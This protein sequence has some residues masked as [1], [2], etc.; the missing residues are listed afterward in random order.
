MGDA[1]MRLLMMMLT[2]LL[3][4][5]PALAMDYTPEELKERLADA[6]VKL[7]EYR[8]E[9]ERLKTIGYGG[10][11]LRKDLEL[12][13]ENVAAL[14][15]EIQGINELLSGFE[16]TPLIGKAAVSLKASDETYDGPPIKGSLESGDIIALQGTVKVPGEE[17]EMLKSYVTWQLFDAKGEQ[18]GDYYKRE[19]LWKV[20]EYE[21]RV[22]F[23]IQDLKSGQYT[24]ALS[25]I[26]ADD[27]SQM[28]QAKVQFT[29]SAPLFFHDAWI[30]DSPG[31]PPIHVLKPGSKP[32]F[33][34]TFGVDPGID[35][36]NVQLRAKDAATGKDLSLEIVDYEV[37]PDK[38]EQR[39]GIMLEEYAVENVAGVSFEARLS[40]EDGPPMVVERTVSKIKQSYALKVRAV[41]MVMSNT[42][43]TY[44][45]SLPEEFVPP[46]RVQ[47]SSPSLK[48]YGEG[49]GLKGQFMGTAQGADKQAVINIRVTDSQ[50]RVAQGAA[51]ITVKAADAKVV[52]S[53][54]QPKLYSSK[55]QTTSPSPSSSSGTPSSGEYATLGRQRVTRV[56]S[57]IASGIGPPCASSLTQ[58]YQ[59]FMV[60]KLQAWTSH[61]D[62]MD[63]VGRMSS[64]EWDNWVKT[65]VWGNLAQAVAQAVAAS[66]PS[67]CYQFMLQNWASAGRMS[68]SV[69]NQAIASNKAGGRGSKPTSV[70]MST[71]AWMQGKP[72]ASSG[73]GGYQTKKKQCTTR[74]VNVE[75]C[76]QRYESCMKQCPKTGT[77]KEIQDCHMRCGNIDRDCKLS[78]CPG[79]SISGVG[80]SISCKICQ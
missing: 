33:Y 20:G 69:A 62:G 51:R 23:L 25:H 35:K 32:Y 79:G 17:G 2:L 63:E 75:D 43:G 50:G 8:T 72:K 76:R 73:G 46:F 27:P 6:K 61:D 66:P 45:V 68:H 71:P 24:A 31:G 77:H 15:H 13:G 64:F 1:V 47:S 14:I 48:V 78:K 41:P 49:N 29:V 5:V 18:V 40:I 65:N 36:V 34:V 3:L 11:V 21:T 38:E 74:K 12:L 53:Q 44:S 55:P 22:R 26:P 37:K 30:T 4:S 60:N 10:P 54:K 56:V 39:I 16:A 7:L 19:E 67:D 57:S 9:Y 52:A 42:K 28:A 59:S 58:P 70:P 80:W